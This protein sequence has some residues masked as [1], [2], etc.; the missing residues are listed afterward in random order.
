MLLLGGSG[1]LITQKTR[2]TRPGT[3]S[4]N[5][6]EITDNIIYSYYYG[7]ISEKSES[8]ICHA[9]SC[10]DHTAPSKIRT[11]SFDE[12][13]FPRN[14]RNNYSGGRFLYSFFFAE[15]LFHTVFGPPK[16]Q[17]RDTHGFQKKKG[18]KF[19]IMSD[20]FWF[21]FYKREKYFLIFVCTFFALS[22]VF[23]RGLP[24]CLK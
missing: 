15:A 24:L 10:F 7:A 17:K 5:K 9:E 1:G 16:K 12:T 20:L 6:T 21:Y 2:K 22:P 3:L 18:R 19:R 23:C 8:A 14:S 11:N 4:P 13:L